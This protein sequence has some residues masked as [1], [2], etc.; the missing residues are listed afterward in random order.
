MTGCATSRLFCMDVFVD[1]NLTSDLE[2]CGGV[3]SK[4]PESTGWPAWIGINAG[5][6]LWIF[7]S[8]ATHAS[9]FMNNLPLMSSQQ[10]ERRSRNV[11]LAL[12]NH[13]QM[14]LSK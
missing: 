14:A 12:V 5:F 10:P 8:N 11:G 13:C 4:P 2:L 6:S 3:S 9:C 1:R 7:I